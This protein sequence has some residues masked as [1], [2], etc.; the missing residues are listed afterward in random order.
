MKKIEDLSFEMGLFLCV[1]AQEIL[2]VVKYFYDLN[3]RHSLVKQGNERG[4]GG[5]WIY[6]GF[7]LKSIVCVRKTTM[8]EKTFIM[9]LLI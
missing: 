7:F 2:S 6:L 5:R 1:C 4:L 8:M 9:L 3:Q